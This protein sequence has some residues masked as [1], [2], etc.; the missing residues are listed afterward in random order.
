[1]LPVSSASFIAFAKSAI[2][3]SLPERFEWQVQ[4]VPHRLAVQTASHQLTYAMLNRLANRIAHAILAR[5][6][7]AVEPVALLLD[8]GAPLIAAILGILK[9]GKLYVALDHT[10]PQAQLADMLV[11]AQPGLMITNQQHMALASALW[12]HHNGVLNLDRLDSSLSTANPALTIAPD[13]LAYIFYTSGST[14]RPKGVVDTHRNVLHNI[15]RYTNSL[16]I[17]AEDR[18]TLLQSCSFSG[19][20]S[21]LFCALLNGAAVLPFDVRAQGLHTL[22]AWLRQEGLTIYHSV[23]SIFRQVATAG[24]A[25]PALRLIRLEGDQASWRDI[26]LYQQHFPATCV[27]VNGL[28]ATECGLVRQFFV[29]QTTPVTGSVVPIGYAVDDMEILLLDDTGQEVP[30]GEIGEIAVCSRYLAAG[31]WGRPDL[32]AAAFQTDAH[33]AER[34]TYHTGDLGRLRPD[35]CLEHLGRKNFQHKI[36]GHRVEVADIETALLTHSA[37]RD[38]VVVTHAEPPHEARLIAYIVP[39]TGT[40]PTV[41]TLR[42]HLVERLPEYMLPAVY[43][44]LAALPLDANGKVARRLLPAPKVQRAHLETPYVPP[45]TPFEEKLAALWADVLQL[46][47]VGIHDHFVELGGDSLSATQLLARVLDAFQLTLPLRSLLEAT[48]VAEMAVTLVQYQTNTVDQDEISRLLTDL[49]TFPEAHTP[50]PS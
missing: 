40:A 8:Q 39:T 30:I 27:L 32:T 7:P 6:G 28:G 43:M 1:M 35:G 47:C 50:P 15:M 36:R 19:S 3:Q 11:D 48:T 24:E 34:R 44:V 46:E 22:A 23:P 10:Y 4:R 18:L 13:A 9:A 49:E 41:S 20:V 42:R 21:S 12:P 14:G 26:E 25:F 37:I 31:Y 17:C 16:R 5:R 45:S 38:A 29:E 33:D 2:A